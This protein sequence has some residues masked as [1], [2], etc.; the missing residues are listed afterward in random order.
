MDG[1][2]SY[3]SFVGGGDFPQFRA[4]S[5]VETADETVLETG[6]DRGGVYPGEAGHRSGFLLGY[7]HDCGVVAE[8]PDFDYAVGVAGCEDVE[9]GRGGRGGVVSQFVKSDYTPSLRSVA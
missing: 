7:F 9:P 2:A 4:A 6:D 3:F 8:V 1:D 5:G